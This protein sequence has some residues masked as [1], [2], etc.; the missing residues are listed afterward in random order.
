MD[1]P[2]PRDYY[3]HHYT[4]KFE[5]LQAALREGIWPRYVEEDL[6]EILGGLGQPIWLGCPM[7]CFTDMNPKSAHSHRARY[8]DYAL[9][10]SKD[11]ARKADIQPLIYLLGDGRLAR[12]IRARTRPNQG[13]VDLSSENPFSVLLPFVKVT[14]G[15]QRMREPGREETW[16]VLGLEEEL[17]WRYV[18][19]ALP[20]KDSG[21]HGRITQADQ[22]LAARHK[23]VIPEVYLESVVVTSQAEAVEIFREFRHLRE[24]IVIRQHDG[25]V[26]RAQFR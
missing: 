2:A 12:E 4:P 22:D 5:Y 23:L 10:V 1:H 19:G 20:I 16:E 14:P 6:S 26:Q 17:E 11:F 18:P 8:G 21:G 3:L 7:V 9:V 13:R 25:S 15:S 24:K